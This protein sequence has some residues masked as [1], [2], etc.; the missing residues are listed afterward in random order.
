MLNLVKQKE[1]YTRDIATAKGYIQYMKVHQ[2]KTFD[3]LTAEEYL[4]ILAELEDELELIQNKLDN[5][6]V[7]ARIINYYHKYKL[8]GG[9]LNGIL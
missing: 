1:I 9:F 4:E 2:L 8:Y 3:E 6:G 5:A 7:V